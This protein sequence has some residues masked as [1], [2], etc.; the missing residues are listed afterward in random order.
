MCKDPMAKTEGERSA[1][2][3]PK[4]DDPVS[5]N[6]TCTENA[7]KLLTATATT[8]TDTT[9]IND[10]NNKV[11][12]EIDDETTKT[13]PQILMEILTSDDQTDTISWL[14]HGSSFIIHKKKSFGST[15]L[16]K[17][18]K[19]TKFTSFT[20]KLNRWGFTRVT[21]GP[22]MGSYYHRQ[23]LRDSPELCLRMSSHTS[24]KYKYREP[25]NTHHVQ[26]QLMTAIGPGGVTFPFYGMAPAVMPPIPAELSQQNQYINQQL[27]QL[28]WRQYQLQQFQQQQLQITQQGITPTNTGGSTPVVKANSNGRNKNAT[29]NANA[30]NDDESQ[31]QLT[32]ISPPHSIAHHSHPHQHQ[33]L[34][35]A[36]FY[37]HHPHHQYGQQQHPPLQPHPSSRGG[38]ES[39]ERHTTGQQHPSTQTQPQTHDYQQQYPTQHHPYPHNVQHDQHQHAGGVHHL[40]AHTHHTTAQQE[41]GEPPGSSR[42][43]LASTSPPTTTTIGR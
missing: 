2:S 28:Q 29:P 6:T 26:P 42:P 39:G 24:S 11:V 1:D 37:T 31:Q 15:V 18:F 40:P 12:K 9:S 32:S 38:L 20:R 30:N 19:A 8:S 16:P 22:E 43:T 14:P 17:F 3:T 41:S 27:Q 4:F 7:A 21:R 10:S 36:P 34:S 35:V 23:F 33:H 25:T 13:F 5:T